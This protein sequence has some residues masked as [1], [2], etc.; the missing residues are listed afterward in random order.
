MSFWRPPDPL[1]SYR[2]AEESQGWA[3]FSDS[4]VILEITLGSPL[5]ANGV[6]DDPSLEIFTAPYL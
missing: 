4:L 6:D 3:A 5:K 2:E 1:Y